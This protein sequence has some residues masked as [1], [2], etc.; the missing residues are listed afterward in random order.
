MGSERNRISQQALR[1]LSMKTKKTVCIFAFGFAALAAS[2]DYAIRSFTVDGGGGAS[3]GGQFGIT[4]TIAQPDAGGLA[5]GRFSIAGG[6]WSAVSVMQTPG[7]P[8]LSIHPL[9]VTVRISWP[10]PAT[11]F[12]LEQ[13]TSLAGPWLPVSSPYTT[14]A[15]EISISMPAS[16]HMVV[17]RLRHP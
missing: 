10:A 5:G 1:H 15:S 7:A 2:A 16:G 17:Y 3:R 13:A 6:F 12:V 4:G 14:N 8:L 9:G 11:G